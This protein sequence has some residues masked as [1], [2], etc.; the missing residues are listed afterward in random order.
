MRR[1]IRS[2]CDMGARGDFGHDPAI[3]RVFGFLT[4]DRLRDNRPVAAHQRNG[5][6]IAAGFDSQYDWGHDCVRGVR[7]RSHPTSI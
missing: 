2:G 6:F 7:C 1:I 5:G 3:G 4:G